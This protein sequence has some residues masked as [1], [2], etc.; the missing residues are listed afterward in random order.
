MDTPRAVLFAL[1]LALA[2][3]VEAAVLELKNGD[4]ITGSILDKNDDVVTVMTEMAG[5]L[6]IPTANIAHIVETPDEIPPTAALPEAPA[7]AAQTPPAASPAPTVTKGPRGLLAM[8]SSGRYL[9]GKVR[10]AFE[11]NGIL[12]KWKSSVRFGFSMAKAETSTFN[13]SAAAHTER[14][15]SKDELKLDYQQDYATTRDADDNKTVTRDKMKVTA[16]YRHLIGE[17]NFFQA[18]SQYS[19]A[20]VSGIRNDWLQSVGYGWKCLDTK[21]LKFSLIPSLS[22]HYQELDESDTGLAVAPTLYQDFEYIWTE[23]V[24]VKSHAYAVFPA[25]DKGDPSYHLSV[26]LQNRLVGN[27]SLN[28]EYVFDYDGA[29]S[30]TSTSTEQILRTAFSFEF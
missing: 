14:K 25:N 12:G 5:R 24:K 17:R 11:K 22:L 27:L 20:H 1:S 15:W 3:P 19:Y 2:C 6:N 23:Y 10:R 28:V 4:R 8:T 30:T 26:L 21:K 9:V 16:Q 13:T 18:D 7:P 29:V